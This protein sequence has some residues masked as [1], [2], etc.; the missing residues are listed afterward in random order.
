[1]VGKG[2]IGIIISQCK[3]SNKTKSILDEGGITL[4]EGLEAEKVE[5]L[6]EEIEKEI[7]EKE[8]E[9]E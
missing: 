4:Y 7:I 1:M 6:L 8:G 3:V 9:S 2:T 5:V